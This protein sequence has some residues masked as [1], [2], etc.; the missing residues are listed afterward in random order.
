MKQLRL[1]QEKGSAPHPSKHLDAFKH[2]CAAGCSA[3]IQAE[4]L[5]L[6]GP[7]E[8][9]LVRRQEMSGTPQNKP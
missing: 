5:L 7:E 9:P 6:P 8:V 3:S 4:E 2:L 1:L